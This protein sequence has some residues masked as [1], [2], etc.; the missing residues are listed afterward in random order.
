LLVI[1]RG[2][3]E[4]TGA[5]STSELALIDMAVCAYANAMRIQSIIGNTAL[6]LEAELFGQ[7]SLQ[8]RYENDHDDRSSDR[9]SAEDHV[10]ALR[11]RLLPSVEKFHRVARESIEAVGR[12]RKAP[13]MRV[14]RTEAISIV[15]IDIPPRRRG[16]S[17]D[18]SAIE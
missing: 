17:A 1:R 9:L 12:I 3:I 11:E 14:E 18:S 4:E 8:S 7:A 5:T 6:L 13:A 10:A 16:L 15:L 2:L